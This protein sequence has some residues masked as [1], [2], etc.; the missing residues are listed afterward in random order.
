LI[1]GESTSRG[2]VVTVAL[3]VEYL[4]I[5]PV[6][7]LF[8]P[9]HWLPS[10]HDEIRESSESTDQ[11]DEHRD[12][13]ESCPP[14]PRQCDEKDEPPYMPKSWCCSNLAVHAHDATVCADPAGT[15]L[16]VGPTPPDFLG[17]QRNSWAG[18]I[19]WAKPPDAG[20]K[21]LAS[22]G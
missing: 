13:R 12:T 19:C 8:G 7:F 6:S 11:N 4:D 22:R 3:D 9:R 16:D 10:A 21:P 1:R 15:V 5:A 18:G 17:T 20:V 2:C 14:H